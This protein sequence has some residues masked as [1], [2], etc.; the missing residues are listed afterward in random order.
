MLCCPCP[1]PVSPCPHP[2]CHPRPPA[3]SRSRWA[4]A[5]QHPPERRGFSRSPEAI[6]SSSF[7]IMNCG[8][9]G[10]LPH[11]CIYSINASAN[12]LEEIM[13]SSHCSL[14]GRALQRA[15]AA[16]EP[17]TGP[18]PAS[19]GIWDTAGGQQPLTSPSLHPARA[20]DRQQHH[21]GLF[22]P[23]P[24]PIYFPAALGARGRI[25]PGEQQQRGGWILTY[26]HPRAPARAETF[27]KSW[28]RGSWLG[29]TPCPAPVPLKGCGG[30]P[31]L[32]PHAQPV[33]GGEARG[34]DV[35]CGCL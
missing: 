21:Q 23:Q 29:S 26:L 24:S 32:L 15:S 22:I 8:V 34:P 6:W 12:C 19:M 17:A 16:T 31:R 13:C 4:A 25:Q 28:E 5:R 33:P 27:G 9:A 30:I 10:Q 3:P 20:G 18:H 7:S 11:I 14:A 35:L 2:R 1:G